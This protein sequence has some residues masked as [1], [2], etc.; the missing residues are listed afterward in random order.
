MAAGSPPPDDPP[1]LRCDVSELTDPDLRTIGMLAAMAL[2]TRR[3]GQRLALVH[4]SPALRALVA[5][6]G[7]EDVLPFADPPARPG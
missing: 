7:L 6:V 5:F 3:G 1:L 2:V 4:A